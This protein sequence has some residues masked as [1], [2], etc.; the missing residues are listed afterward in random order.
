[1]THKKIMKKCASKLMKD[2]EHYEK[3]MKQTHSKTKKK[4][5]KIEKKEALSAARDLKKRSKKAH[6]YKS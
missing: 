6:E 2:A 5:D 3:D 4:H 1:M